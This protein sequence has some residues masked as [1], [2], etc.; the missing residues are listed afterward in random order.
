MIVVLSDA[1]AVG[2]SSAVWLAISLVIAV[3]AS[4]WSSERLAAA[5]PFTIL[6]PWE[7]EGAVWQRLLRVRSWKDRVPEAGGMFDRDRSKRTVRSRAT[8][9][10]LSLRAETVRAERVHWLIFAS[11]PVHLI[12]CRPILAGS[13]VVFGVA[14]NAPF[15]V[16][17]RYNRGRLDRV[18]RRRSAPGD[19]P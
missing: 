15:I 8:A 1:W 19:R 10:L 16:I 18:V 17:Q 6:R 3:V 5:G 2:L 4:R 12:W 11:T 13:M 9:D 14:L 7:R